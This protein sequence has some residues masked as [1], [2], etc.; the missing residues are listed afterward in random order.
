MLPQ[1]FGDKRHKGVEHLE[2]GFEEADGG[3]VGG[4]VDGLCLAIDVG[5]LHHLQIPAGELVPEQAVN[6]H[7]RLGDTV[8]AEQVVY[9]GIDLFQLGVKPGHCGLS[10]FGRCDVVCY[11]PTLNQAESVPDLVVEVSALFAEGLVE[12]D[13]VAG[14]S[15][16]HHAHAYTVCTKLLD[17]FDRVGRIAEALRHLA[18]EFVAH[19]TGKVDILEREL[20]HILLA[21]HDHAGHPEED[22]VR[23]RYQVAGGII[24]VDF[25]VAGI[26]DTVE[27][28]D[29]PK[30]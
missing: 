10:G 16:Q 19:D 8:L 1:F 25:F 15:R 9:F 2:Q 4:S 27:E 12:E 24:I 6:S 29:G 11:V 21:G 26:I 28:G 20:A 22:D 3:L 14:R 23:S 18:A 17:Q 30:P 13:V 7:Q 5:W